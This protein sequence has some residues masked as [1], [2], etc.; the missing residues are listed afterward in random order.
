MGRFAIQTLSAPPA[1][2]WGVDIY[3]ST[4]IKLITGIWCFISLTSHVSLL[5]IFTQKIILMKLDI[6][7]IGAHPDDIELSCGGTILSHVS[8]GLKVGILDLTRGE[9]GTRGSAEERSAEAAAAAK[10][11][12]VEVRENAGFADGFFVNDKHHQLEL[13]KF[14]RKYR[15][16]IVLANAIH[17]RHPDHARAAQLTEDAVFMSGLAKIETSMDGEA[18]KAFRPRT[19]FHYIQ[20]LDITPDIAVDITPFFD[21]KVEAIRAYKTQFHNP[22]S[23]EPDTFISSPEFLEFIKARASHY[24]VPLGVSYAEGFTIKRHIGVHNLKD[25]F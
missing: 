8:L 18:Q 13:I 23:K 9:L 17:D 12:G 6:L 4:A 14:I 21:K 1:S 25:I 15:P 22:D 24:G 20:S 3:T 5:P 16:D 2:V 11:L 19:V 10:I 7:A